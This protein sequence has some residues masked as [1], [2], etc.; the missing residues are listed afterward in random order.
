MGVA[1]ESIPFVR[2]DPVGFK[3][4]PT[5]QRREPPAAGCTSGEAD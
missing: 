1:H 2:N 3:G 4:H 5:T